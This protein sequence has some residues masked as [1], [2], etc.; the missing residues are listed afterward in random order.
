MGWQVWLVLGLALALG[1]LLGAA[2]VLLCFGAAALV[3]A[4][5]AA[6][7]LETLW[8]QLLL[9]AA[10]L[11]PLVL[12][13][14]SLLHRLHRGSP[15]ARVRTAVHALPGEIARVISAIDNASGAGRVELHGLEWTARSLD[16]RPIPEGAR[17]R[18]IQVDGVKL[19]V[20]PEEGGV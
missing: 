15:G 11:G 19:I 10:L 14:R 9:F 3:V 7:G 2:L 8:K 5:A 1:E 6:V 18:V 4:G 20:D 12:I 17:V 13:G 16:E